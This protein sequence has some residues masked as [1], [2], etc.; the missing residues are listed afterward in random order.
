MNKAELLLKKNVVI[1]YRDKKTVG[2]LPTDRDA[3]VVGVTEKIPLSCLAPEDRIPEQ[4]DGI[5]TDVIETEPIRAL[6]AKKIPRTGRHRPMPGGV[7][8]GH[9]QVSAGTIS[10]LDIEGT[11]YIASNAHVIANCG[12]CEVGDLIW[13]PG[14]LDG[15]TIEDTIGHLAKWV[16]IHFVDD[17]D[18]CPLA[19]LFERGVNWFLKLTRFHHRIC[20]YTTRM[21]KVDAAV[22]WPIADDDVLLEVLDIGVPAGFGEARIGNILKKSGRTTELLQGPVIDTEGASKVSYGGYGTALF[23]DQIITRKIAEPGDSGSL[24]FREDNV[25]VGWLFAGNNQF[26]IVN[27]IWNILEELDMERS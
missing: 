2:G 27:K 22:G 8:G 13:Q 7:S 1:V 14:R 24:V 9:P 6:P 4:I 23:D 12:D 17:P 5:E 15:G 26:T 16:P 21:N 20:T 11:K 3:I 18:S 25:L 10:G 19:H